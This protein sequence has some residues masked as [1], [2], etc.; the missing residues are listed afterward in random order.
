MKGTP[1]EMEGF[2]FDTKAVVIKFYVVEFLC[3]I[4]PILEIQA[5]FH[6]LFSSLENL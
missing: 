3:D 1:P 6:P 2:S 4:F 5:F